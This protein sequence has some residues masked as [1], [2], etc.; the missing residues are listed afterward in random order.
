[1]KL[2][3]K[4]REEAIRK[5]IHA[6]ADGKKVALSAI[7]LKSGVEQGTVKALYD[8]KGHEKRTISVVTASKL[9]KG[10][11]ELEK[12]AGMVKKCSRCGKELPYGQFWANNGKKDGLQS[13]CKDCM[14]VIIAKSKEKKREKPVNDYKD[15]PVTAE[16]VKKVKAED[17]KD[18]ESKFMAPYFGISPKQLDEVRRGQWDSLLFKVKTPE[19][20]TSVQ[21]AVEAL[22][23]EIADMHTALNVLM[24]EMGCEVKAS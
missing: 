2:A 4:K 5:R 10:L 17:K 14:R 7:G 22:R 20:A 9:E 8:Q 13:E 3:D 11:D 1:M 21:S 6:L 12:S 15:K 18:V 23:M 24:H 16:I 19:P